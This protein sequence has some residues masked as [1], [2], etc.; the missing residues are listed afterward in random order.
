MNPGDAN[1]GICSF[2]YGCSSSEDLK[3]APAGRLAVSF[4]DGPAAGTDL[5]WRYMG[6]NRARGVGTHFMIGSYIVNK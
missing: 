2:T 1:G 5:L 6:E 3:D 4:D